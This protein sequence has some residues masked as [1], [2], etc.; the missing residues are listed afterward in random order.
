MHYYM[1]SSSHNILLCVISMSGWHLA[2]WS[3]C[4]DLPWYA[5]P[6]HPTIA[7]IHRMQG[8]QIDH[9]RL[10]SSIGFSILMYVCM[11][12]CMHVRISS[13]YVCVYARMIMHNCIHDSLW[14]S[15]KICMYV[16]LYVC[17]YVCMY[18]YFLYV[19]IICT[20]LYILQIWPSDDKLRRSG[21]HAKAALLLHR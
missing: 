12:V 7:A 17:M 4:V 11:Y 15:S 21:R 13:V 8:K 19:W 5:G 16:C 6:I 3:C 18:V 10:G 14:K 2:R 20:I 9:P 1:Q